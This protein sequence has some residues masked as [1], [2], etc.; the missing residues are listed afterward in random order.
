MREIKVRAWDIKAKI[1][2][3]DVTVYGGGGGI[4]F[5]LEYEKYYKDF[6]ESND[7]YVEEY[8]ECGDDWLWL[9]EGFQL[10][11]YIGCKD[12]NVREI[13][14]GDRIRWYPNRPKN[15]FDEVVEWD[16]SRLCF[17][18]GGWYENDFP[19]TEKY[20][21]IIGNIYKNPEL[22]KEVK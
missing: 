15:H 12:K 21:K 18:L 9:L 16:E 22:A 20:C 4:G 2:L 8:F 11:L 10:M 6:F 14:E 19:D 1:M 7:R 5:P 3:P 13:Y 17:T